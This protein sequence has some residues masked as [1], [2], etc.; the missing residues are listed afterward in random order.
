MPF[1]DIFKRFSS[2]KNLR[3]L[4]ALAEEIV[5]IKGRVAIALNRR[6]EIFSRIL[7]SCE[8]LKADPLNKAERRR[9]SWYLNVEVRFLDE[10]RKGIKDSISILEITLK[11]LGN[12]QKMQEKRIKGGRN[13]ELQKEYFEAIT[14]MQTIQFLVDTMQFAKEKIKVIEKRIE[15]GEKLEESDYTGRHFKEFLQTL[16]DEARIDNELALILE[17]KS[18]K[19]RSNLNILRYMLKDKY[20]VAAGLTTAAAVG[21]AGYLGQSYYAG[22]GV[23][24]LPDSIPSFAALIIGSSLAMMLALAG[25]TH[26]FEE[27]RRNLKGRVGD[28]LKIPR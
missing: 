10:V 27:S 6:K 19:V 9:L 3:D 7:S 12:E 24:P 17:G 22:M 2:K 21:G 23:S 1:S 25:Q 26:M 16:D 8:K 13:A 20:V 14:A 15:K 18:K 11:E 5:A 4:K 28:I